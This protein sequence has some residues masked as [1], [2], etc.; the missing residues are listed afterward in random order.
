MKYKIGDLVKLNVEGKKVFS[1]YSG[2]DLT[3]KVLD[4]FCPCL[5]LRSIDN[6][7]GLTTIE[8]EIEPAGFKYTCIKI[9]NE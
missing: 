2:V 5:G 1:N 7:V 3:Y 8:A 4:I 6:K 9:L